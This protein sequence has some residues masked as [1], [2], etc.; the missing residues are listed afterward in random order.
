MTARSKMLRQLLAQEEEK[1]GCRIEPALFWEPSGSLGSIEYHNPEQWTVS[2]NLFPFS[3]LDR[4]LSGGKTPPE[5]CR[6][7]KLYLW[8][9]LEAQLRLD[10]LAL[11]E[12]PD[13]WL[14]G[15]A[16]LGR[17]RSRELDHAAPLSR[18]RGADGALRKTE[19]LWTPE[20]RFCDWL[21][22][23]K[24]LAFARLN[25]K[26][27]VPEEFRTRAAEAALL[28][29][30]PEV[31]YRKKKQPYRMAP[32]LSEQ[33]MELLEH[34]ASREGR[35]P[36]FEP[37]AR[38]GEKNG[39][40]DIWEALLTESGPFYG[41]LALRLL[42]C[43]RLPEGAER[44]KDETVARKLRDAAAAYRTSARD[45]VL[46]SGGNDSKVLLANRI[47]AERTL[48]E[49]EALEELHLGKGEQTRLRGGGI[50]PYGP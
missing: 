2:V 8:F 33:W 31:L 37:L 26:E 20:N 27:H 30:L 41:A 39:T 29:A 5:S 9:Y 21:A 48:R 44:L 6:L 23:E 16:V 46:S 12:K 35:Y 17:I 15:L 22:M 13:S 24:T 10:T 28:A 32:L 3:G 1:T 47:A 50:H 42:L 11:K 4:A 43:G 25:D 40:A 38:C 34:P 19:K 18:I 36:I 14:E 49:I 7:R 45:F